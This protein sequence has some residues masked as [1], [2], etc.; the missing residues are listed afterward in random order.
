MC[1]HVSDDEN[2][3]LANFVDSSRTP[4]SKYLKNEAKFLL[5][6]KKSIHDILSVMIWQKI[7]YSK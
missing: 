5:Q 1:N 6:M 3:F 7:V 2:C 4:K